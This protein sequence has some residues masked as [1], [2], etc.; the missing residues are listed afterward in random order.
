MK[1]FQVQT[2]EGLWRRHDVAEVMLVAQL[3][4]NQTWHRTMKQS[5]TRLK[6]NDFTNRRLILLGLNGDNWLKLGFGISKRQGHNLV[7][8]REMGLV[9]WL[10]TAKKE[11]TPLMALTSLAFGLYWSNQV[12]FSGSLFKTQQVRFDFGDLVAQ[13]VEGGYPQLVSLAGWN[14]DWPIIQ[15][16][17]NLEAVAIDPSAVFGPHTQAS[18]LNFQTVGKSLAKLKPGLADWQSTNYLAASVTGQTISANILDLIVGL[19]LKTT[20]HHYYRQA[21]W[22]QLWLRYLQTDI[23]GGLVLDQLINPSDPGPDC[24]RFL[25]PLLKAGRPNG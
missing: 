6:G 22:S 17:F 9:G 7:A 13:S 14:V 21:L 18:D 12:Y 20:S 5:Y 23:I 15:A 4:E 16:Y 2:I 10:P 25:R 8:C 1:F 3:V 11:I 19:N 24:P